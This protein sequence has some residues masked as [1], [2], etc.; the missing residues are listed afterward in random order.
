MTYNNN[1][2][3]LLREHFNLTQNDLAEEFNKKG[4][5]CN[6]SKILNW[7]GKSSPNFSDLKII[8]DFF[9]I[10]LDDFLYINLE[11]KNLENRLRKEAPKPQF[12]VH[13]ATV[14]QE[15]NDIVT[16][17]P[18]KASAGYATNFTDP[19]F[20]KSLRK[21]DIPGFSDSKSHRAFE[22]KGDSMPPMK[23]KDIVIGEKCFD[24]ESIK[25][26]EK[27]I[28]TTKAD[29]Y[30]FKN[31]YRDGDYFILESENSSYEPYEVHKD[32]VLEFWK[33]KTCIF[34]DF[35]EMEIGNTLFSRNLKYLR[36]IKHKLSLKEFSERL[37]QDGKGIISVEDLRSFEMG[38]EPKQSI[39]IKISD[40]FKVSIDQ[41]LTQNV[42]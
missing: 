20:Y 35:P 33:Y 28:V 9:K 1:N 30:V 21:I 38:V 8:V 13:M 25:L 24:K 12:D 27:Y 32:E 5:K 10:S 42:R 41:L 15:G 22:I 14:D 34:S 29:G 18:Q 23:S 19:E 3:K 26:G 17:V 39:L 37:N 16:L 7:E 31:V 36:G 6:R 40:F 2:L 11:E 4:M